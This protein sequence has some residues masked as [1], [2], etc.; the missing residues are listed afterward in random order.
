MSRKGF[1]RI[2]EHLINLGSDQEDIGSILQYYKILSILTA[3]CKISLA[4]IE[5]I[6]LGI[7]MPQDLITKYVTVLFTIK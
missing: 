7:R 6:E 2:H 1:E 4:K 3:S 5:P